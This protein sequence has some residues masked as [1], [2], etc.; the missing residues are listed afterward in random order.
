VALTG[1]T[2]PGGGGE[3]DG[4]TDALHKSNDFKKKPKMKSI[5][6]IRVVKNSSRNDTHIIVL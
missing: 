3:R 5:K 2:K 4:L 1:R 6:L